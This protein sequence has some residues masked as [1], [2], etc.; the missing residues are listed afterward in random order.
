MN[1]S[2]LAFCISWMFPTKQDRKNFRKL[3]AEIEIRKINQKVQMRYMQDINNFKKALNC[4]PPR[5]F[6]NQ[7]CIFS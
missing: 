6:K 2:I 4:P 1:Y 3:C 7:G 5:R